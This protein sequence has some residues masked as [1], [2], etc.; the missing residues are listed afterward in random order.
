M[1]PRSGA[2]VVSALALAI[3][4]FLLIPSFFYAGQL[5]DLD[6]SF[7]TFSLVGTVLSV[8]LAA[9]LIAFG[10]LLRPRL[11]VSKIYLAAAVAVAL[12]VVFLASYVPILDGEAE[13]SPLA[14]AE[15]LWSIASLLVAIGIGVICVY[16]FNLASGLVLAVV[17]ALTLQP[18]LDGRNW[19]FDD[20]EL[21]FERDDP[22][23]QLLTFSSEQ[24][25]VL[26]VLIDTFASDVFAQIVEENESFR[27]AMTGFTF[28][29]NTV[30][31]SA[32]TMMS[33]M[34][35]Y[36]GRYYES[37]QIADLYQAAKEDGIFSDAQDAGAT[38]TLGGF[39][40]Y[41]CPAEHCWRESQIVRTR[42]IDGSVLTYLELVENGMLRFAP[43]LMHSWMYNGGRGRLRA[44][45][46][47]SQTH[48][49]LSVRAVDDFAR[50]LK[51]AEGPPTFK[52]LH[53]MTTHSPLILNERCG[54][55]SPMSHKWNDYKQQATC[56]VRGFVELL[57]AMKKAGVYDNTTIVLMGDHGAS[58]SGKPPEELIFDVIVPT[59]R[60]VGR[61][62]PVFAIKPKN[63]PTPFAISGA[64]AELRDLRKTLCEISFECQKDVS[65][66][67]LFSLEA[68]SDRTRKFIDYDH[69]AMQRHV[70]DTG[71]LPESAIHRYEIGGSLESLYS[72]YDRENLPPASKA[73]P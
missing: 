6:L 3:S 36:S 63:V 24:Q 58:I 60:R 62:R 12:K 29:Y 30:S 32:Y 65:G 34:T 43:T 23:E 18:L 52:F 14:S 51:A 4:I 5:D 15:G 10:L 55:V 31:Q 37:G 17:V 22:P 44:Y 59:V 21:S 70:G 61:F 49:T 56:A 54:M 11:D 48:G 35:V 38:T 41:D 42:P 27:D 66:E 68:N 64:P 19:V 16:Y 45:L 69:R 1:W 40:F 71:T 53:L 26:V 9:I 33:M 57:N 2:L 67:N 46:D 20:G 39:H 73:K 47:P 72:T 8:G 13:F 50:S 25:N 7:G 28:F